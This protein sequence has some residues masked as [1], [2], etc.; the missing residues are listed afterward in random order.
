MKRKNLWILILVSLVV[1]FVTACAPS[2]AT[3]AAPS[4]E[5]N[6]INLVDGLGET[7]RLE[8][9]AT[10]VLSLAPSNTEIL[11]AIGAGGQVVGREDFSNFPEEVKNIPSVGGSMGKYNMEEIAKLQPDL[12]LASPLTAPEILKSL[13]DITPNVFVLPNPTTLEG[14]YTNLRTVGQLTGR[15]AETEELIASLTTRV[16]TVTTKLAGVTERPTVFYELD[17]TDPAKP[18]TAGKGTFIDMLIQ[19][20]AGENIAGKL[21]GEYPQISQEALIIENPDVILLGDA[22]YG[23]ITAESVAARPGWE[24]IAAVKNNRV[25]P[26]NDDLVSRPGPRM[27]EGLEELA[28]VLHPELFQ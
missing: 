14:M 24:G 5:T 1:L 6:E 9:P 3:T 18:W 12:V 2:V 11:Y 26:F 25:L 15:Q 13:K 23:G 16:T 21:E 19:M 17:A 22:L 10:R 7:I 20:A 27:V 8:K 28:K 4:A